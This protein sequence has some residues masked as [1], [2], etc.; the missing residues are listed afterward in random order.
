MPPVVAVAAT[1]I[2]GITWASVATFA[3]K[4]VISI[5]LSLA[6]SKLFGPSGKKP[7]LPDD[8]ASIKEMIRSGVA[9][10]RIIYGERLV[11]GTLVFAKT[12][13]TNNK[14]LHMVI[15]LAGHEIEFI[16]DVYFDDKLSTDP[17]WEKDGVPL[18]RIKYHRGG[19]TQVADADLVSEIAEWTTDH[20]LLETAYIYVRFEFD[21]DVY[22]KIPNI[23][24]KVKGKKIY[25]P[26]TGTTA[27]SDNWALCVRDY[28]SS[29]DGFEALADELPDSA[30]S[31]A[32]NLSDELVEIPGGG[33]QKRYTLN[34]AFDLSEIPINV[35]TMM[36][37]AAQANITYSQGQYFPNAAAY[38]TP[39][40]TLTDDDLRDEVQ[41]QPRISRKSLFNA[42]R[43]TYVEPALTYTATDFKP[44]T[45]TT[46]EAQDGG[47]RIYRDLELPFTTCAICSQRLARIAL[48]R[49][50]RQG[51]LRFPAK[52]RGLQLSA[53]DN[54]TVSI[55]RFGWVNKVFKVIDWNPVVG[56]AD[57]V[58][59]EEDADI[60]VWN[61]DMATTKAISATPFVGN[62]AQLVTGTDPGNVVTL[63]ESGNLPA[64][65]G[66]N[67]ENVILIDGSRAFTAPVAGVDPTT[68]AH[69]A[70]KAYVDAA[71][72]GGGSFTV[73]SDTPG[74]YSGFGG[75][76][77][78]VKGDETGLE[79]TTAGSGDMLKSTYD[80]D[81]DGVVDE[82]SL[83]NGGYF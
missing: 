32:A 34:G 29:K 8:A 35:L 45:N 62:P 58:L 53:Q 64:V 33:T 4:T 75:S 40:M 77:V 71:T 67:L 28:M 65:G 18:F 60:Y 46:Y 1:A 21:Q 10:R 66:Q 37:S 24:A 19:P 48:E 13:G 2:A 38:T 6:V 43:G 47:I 26:R 41:Y 14:Y 61:G 25:D 82:A 83:V 76:V 30:W 15:A 73:L 72:G 51:Q 55:A 23:R 69:L 20:K 11:G 49:A 57:L 79:F 80:T 12:T 5:G 74:S 52:M 39:V 9:P 17:Q 81:D 68:A 56:G 44:V 42:I 31:A 70:T 50:R 27:W 78:S 7:S 16:G 22:T 54:V 59:Q 36:E 3:L 63:D